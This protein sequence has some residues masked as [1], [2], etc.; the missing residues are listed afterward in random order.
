MSISRV[1]QA[2][3]REHRL[4]KQL[5]SRER[6]ARPLPI[7]RTA[8]STEIPAMSMTAFELVGELLIQWLVVAAWS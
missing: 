1:M 3:S 2:C 5:T 6:A 7:V 8:A 4:T